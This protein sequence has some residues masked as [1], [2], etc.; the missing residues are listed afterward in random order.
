LAQE[1]AT[2]AAH[3]WRAIEIKIS[4]ESYVYRYGYDCVDRI[5]DGIAESDADRYVVISDDTVLDL[6]GEPLLEQLG[7]RAPV[8]TLTAP[9]G[10]HMKRAQLVSDYLERAIRWGATRRSVVV[11]FGGGVPGNL[12]GLVAGLLFRGVRLV[13][14]PTT[15]VAAM[16]SVISLKQAVN[17]SVGK[18][19]LGLYHRPHLVL[20]D[21]RMLQTLPRTAVR[22]GLCEFVKN[23]LAIR[24]DFIAGLRQRLRGRDLES[25]LQPDTL[26][27][28][29]HQSIAAKVQVMADDPREC[30]SGL[31]LEYGHTIGHAVELCDQQARGAAGISHGEAIGLG[32]IASARLS[33]DLGWL[34][35]D[36][37]RVHE[38]LLGLL[39]SQLT[40]PSGVDPDAVTWL[41]ARDNKRGYLRLADDE[42]AMVLLRALGEPA[43]HPTMPLVPVKVG[44]VADVVHQLSGAAGSVPTAVALSA[45]RA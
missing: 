42:A 34:D 24:P 25:A 26:L 6:H 32:M 12:A 19:H 37:V 16:D 35:D 22:A 21:V 38:E 28:L 36:A 23:C 27:W 20:T 10:E 44:Q 18:N 29:L 5:V 11:A 4:S 31:V 41:V 14:V 45:D 15:A 8:L 39:N 40:L 43:G 30:R 9:A 3:E 13:H 1:H 17:S 7:R 33:R 2:A